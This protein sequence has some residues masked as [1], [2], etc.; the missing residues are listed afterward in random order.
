MRRWSHLPSKNRVSKIKVEFVSQIKK[1]K[2]EKA[3][4]PATPASDRSTKPRPKTQTAAPT[5][6]HREYRVPMKYQVRPVT[7]AIVRQSNSVT[8]VI[9]EN[10]YALLTEKSFRIA[11]V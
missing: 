11:S 9:D 1:V 8:L 10:W 2:L 6:C 5:N 3:P 7:H 4:P